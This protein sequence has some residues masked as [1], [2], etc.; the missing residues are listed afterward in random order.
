MCVCVCVKA[1]ANGLDLRKYIR[2]YVV[3]A[4]SLVQK[5]N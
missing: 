1:D 5:Y 2:M 4:F 3:F